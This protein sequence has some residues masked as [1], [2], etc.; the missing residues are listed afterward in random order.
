MLKKL[1]IAAVA[2]SSVGIAMSATIIVREAPPALREEAAPAPR[3]GYEWAPG[4]WNWNH[5]RYVWTS[6][7]WLRERHGQHWVADRWEQRGDHWSRIGG[8]YERG[9]GMGNR[10]AMG[11]RDHDGVPNA[12]D[13]HPNNPYKN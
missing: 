11:D 5:G 4:Y 1:I 12:V 13:S 9:V 7:H 6:G 3:M 10:G 2:A 8:H